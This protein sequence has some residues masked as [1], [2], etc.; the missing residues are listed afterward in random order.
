MIKPYYQ[1]E[2]ATIYHGDCREIL[3]ALTAKD[4]FCFTDPPYNVGMDYK[5]WNDKLPDEDYLKFCCDW[6]SEVKRICPEMVVYPPR[7]YFLHYWNLLGE[8]FK[9]IVLTWSPEGAIR[10]G[11]VNQHAT[12]LSGAKPKQRTKDWWHN[13]QMRG[14]GY[15]FRENDFGHP[16]YTS[17]DLTNRVLNSFASPVA[18]IIEPFGGSGTT[19]FCAKMTGRKSISIEYSEYWCEQSAKRLQ[20]ECLPFTTTPAQTLTTGELLVDIAPVSEGKCLSSGE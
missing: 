17:E 3:P 6:I 1:D 9:Q 19:A 11:Y 15:F 8:N 5:G 13:C 14:L 12:I 4:G 7:K 2:W 18:T 16:G 20:Q 10:N